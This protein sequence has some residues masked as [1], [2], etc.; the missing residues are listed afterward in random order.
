MNSCQ[1][2]KQLLPPNLPP[3]HPPSF[4]VSKQ[5]NERSC[6]PFHKIRFSEWSEFD[7]EKTEWRIPSRQD[8]WKQS[9]QR[10]QHI[11]KLIQVSARQKNALRVQNWSLHS[12]TQIVN[13]LL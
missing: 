10:D 9:G 13:L 8:E 5:K 3:F 1:K 12:I 7:F 11:L 6:V 4:L 2:E